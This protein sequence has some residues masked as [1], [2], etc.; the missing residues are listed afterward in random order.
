MWLLLNVT[1][2]LSNKRGDSL[3]RND[4]SQNVFPRQSAL[5]D[6]LL[7]KEPISAFGKKVLNSNGGLGGGG[8]KFFSFYSVRRSRSNGCFFSGA[9]PPPNRLANRKLTAFA[10]FCAVAFSPC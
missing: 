2:C 9:P 10:N 7:E 3:A 8:N 6:V 1:Q 4:I 5:A